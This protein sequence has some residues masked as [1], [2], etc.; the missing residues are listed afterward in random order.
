MDECHILDLSSKDYKTASRQVTMHGAR[1]DQ[2]DWGIIKLL[3]EDGRL[4]NAEIA[5]RVGNIS[6]RTVAHRIEALIDSGVIAVK[7][8][9]NPMA[10][11]YA[12]MADVFIEV[13]PGRVKE[14]AEQVAHF[15]QVTYVACATGEADVSLS[16]RVRNNEELFEFVSDTLGKI[17]GVRRTQTYLLP[18]KI[19][20]LDSWL[21]EAAFESN[22]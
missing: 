21:P 7:A 5:R 1:I 12:V 16:L 15:P 18:L 2:T 6:S 19:K 4:S 22:P 13:E 20:D 3:N 9:V 14:V 8:I 11:G 17:P 10:V